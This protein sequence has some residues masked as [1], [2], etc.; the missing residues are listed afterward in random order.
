MNIKTKMKLQ[1][2]TIFTVFILAGNTYAQSV[3]I[4][5]VTEVRGNTANVVIVYVAGGGATNFDFKMDYD[6]TLVDES[7]ITVDCDPTNV[8]LTS[9]TCIIDLVKNQ[10]KGIGVNLL[11]SGLSSGGFVSINLPVLTD[12]AP[13][14]SVSP[15]VGHFATNSNVTLLETNWT[16][17]INTSHCNVNVV[18][19]VT[20]LANAT[21]EACEI[22][23]VG[24]AFIAEDG[25]SVFLS[26]GLAIELSPGFLIN[27]G[28]ILSAD[29]CGQSLCEISSS[30]M[31]IG[32]HSC[33]VQICDIDPAC[34][35]TGFDQSC[36][37]KVDTVCNLV[38]E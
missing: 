10:I 14:A 33:V 15:Y 17:N 29:V 9:L 1:F 20:E 7:A 37:D 13:G 3:D 19:D 28:A 8:G 23:I 4:P 38:C 2:V 11:Q 6:P 16:L 27:K 30:P 21:H 34:C 22:L 18:T 26:S 5:N 31:P 24:P 36:L 25:A 35:D 32:C 12:A